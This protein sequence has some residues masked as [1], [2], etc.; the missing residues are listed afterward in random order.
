M[1]IDLKKYMNER[2]QLRAQ[3]KDP[4]PIVTLSRAYGCEANDITV[5]LLHHINKHLE[6]KSASAKLWKYINKEII[7]DASA[8]LKLPAERIEQRVVQHHEHTGTMGQM[9]ASLGGK[10]G[11]SDKEIIKKVNE[12]I[13]TYAHDGKVIIVGRGGAML[14][15]CIPR[16]IHI[17]LFAPFEWRAAYIADKYRLSQME[18]ETRVIE[19]D[20]QRRLWT[21]HLSGK[22]FDEYLFDVLLNRKTMNT[23]EIVD[24]IFNMMIKR[25]LI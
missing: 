10:W 24:I 13:Q 1:K 11:L 9:F 2:D 5:K 4:G 20:Q 6:S 8:A 16:S 15:R 22:P 17:R 23:E 14:T 18:A 21:E 25:N 19:N 7:N 12:V 3:K